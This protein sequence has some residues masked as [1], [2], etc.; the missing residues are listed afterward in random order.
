MGRCGGKLRHLCSP[1]SCSCFVVV[2]LLPVVVVSVVANVVF[3]IVV[4]LLLPIF[5][6]LLFQ[7]NE[8]PAYMP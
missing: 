6:L 1:C 7:A 3:D 4:V 5:L 2:H 8:L